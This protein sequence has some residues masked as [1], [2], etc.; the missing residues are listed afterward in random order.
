MAELSEL[1]ALLAWPSNPLSAEGR[2]RMFEAMEVLT[3]VIEHEWLRE[4]VSRNRVKVV[5]VCSGGGVAGF[6]LA[7]LLIDRGIDVELVLVDLRG[8]E[9][10]AARRYRDEY[11]PSVKLETYT[12]DAREVHNLGK[13]FD[14]ALLWGFSMPHFSP[15]DALKLFA[16][17][18]LA[19]EPHGVLL[20]EE[21]DRM[22]SIFLRIG[23]KYVLPE[24]LGDKP[25]IGL[26]KA[27]NLLRGTVKRFLVDLSSGKTVQHEVCLSW[28]LPFV[29]AFMW[30]FF[31][32][33]DIGYAVRGGSRA[34]LVARRP[35]RAMDVESFLRAEPSMLSHGDM[36]I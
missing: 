13:S 7:K 23:Y 11:M 26:H 18:A 30:V 16:S 19:L 6:A 24:G 25:V 36:S 28:S 15:W 9:L 32:D 17:I 10:E 27:Y 3:K 4:I 34:V 5:D 33:V 35:R 2:R 31:E 8:E 22:L 21:V 14:I 29:A 20:V 12:M 1:Y